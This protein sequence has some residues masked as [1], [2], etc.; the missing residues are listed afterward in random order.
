MTLL[1]PPAAPENPATDVHLLWRWASAALDTVLPVSCVG[2]GRWDH[3]LCPTCRQSC[4]DTAHT[5]V[6]ADDTTMVSALRY[7]GPARAAILAYKEQFR[8][9]AAAYLA[10]PFRRASLAALA[11]CAP[12]R[13]IE[14][15]TIPPSERS[16]RSRGF[17]P[18]HLLA[19]PARLHVTSRPLR[20]VRT[21]RAQKNLSRDEREVNRRG[22]LRAAEPLVGRRFIVVDDV[23]TTGSTVMEA[24]RA[25]RIAGAEVCAVAALAAAPTRLPHP[26]VD[27]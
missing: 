14:L 7:E 21:P 9:D 15:V 3:T 5:S 16:W 1:P 2:C 17:T 8:V 22:M 6:L 24:A 13:P 18:V 4:G 10:N 20:Y 23:V 25:L 19:R 27:R 11:T 12:G 26:A